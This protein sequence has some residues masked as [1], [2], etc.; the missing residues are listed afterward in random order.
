MIGAITSR[1]ATYNE[2]LLLCRQ[3]MFLRQLTKLAVG[4]VLYWQR[5]SP[6]Y[7][8]RVGVCRLNKAVI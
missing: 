1:K 6:T 8:T 5:G 7:Q 4:F 3:L 2:V